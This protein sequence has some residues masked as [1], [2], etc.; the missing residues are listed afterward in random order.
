M[1]II[2]QDALS[3]YIYIYI[4]IHLC[5]WIAIQ[6]GISYP[7]HTYVYIYIYPMLRYIDTVILSS[8]VPNIFAL[9]VEACRFLLEQRSFVDVATDAAAVWRATVEVHQWKCH[10]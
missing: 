3:L 6:V 10:G 5:N 9:Q 4:Y 8:Y 7:L 1:S 2:S